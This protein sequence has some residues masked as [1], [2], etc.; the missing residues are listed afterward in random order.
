MSIA[1]QLGDNEKN[2]FQLGCTLAINAEGECI[3][4]K[5]Q[6]SDLELVNISNLVIPTYM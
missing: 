2:K 6:A 1:H 3:N 4:I 5:T